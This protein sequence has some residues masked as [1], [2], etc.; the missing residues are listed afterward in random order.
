MTLAPPVFTEGLGDGKDMGLIEG[1]LQGIAP[2][3]AG[4]EA[5]PLIRIIGIGLSLVIGPFELINFNQKF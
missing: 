4:T 3:A 5:H 2:V 1:T